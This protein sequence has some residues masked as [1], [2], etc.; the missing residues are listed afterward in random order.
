[1]VLDELSLDNRAQ[2]YDLYYKM[3]DIINQACM[4][5]STWG[6]ALTSINQITPLPERKLSIN[7]ICVTCTHWHADHI[8]EYVDTDSNPMGDCQCP[9]FHYAHE[10]PEYH[11]YDVDS[12]IYF[13]RD[14]RE[15]NVYTAGGFSCLHWSQR[16]EANDLVPD[17]PEISNVGRP[18]PIGV[19]GTNGMKLGQVKSL[20]KPVFS[21]DVESD[22]LHGPIFAIGAVVMT[23]DGTVT[24][25]FAGYA[26]LPKYKSDWVKENVVQNLPKDSRMRVYPSLLKLRSAF[27]KF[28]MW[29][30]EGVNCLS[31]FGAP[32][33]AKLFSECI[34]DNLSERE[35]QGPYPMHELGTM[36][37]TAG[38]DPDVSREEYSGILDKEQVYGT[39]VKHNPVYDSV[40][41]A[42]A[43]FKCV[44]AHTLG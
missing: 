23:S 33:E 44:Q 3:T 43:W 20:G 28:W 4:G 35:W 27:W 24:A 2:V 18:Q 22:G 38:V 14:G 8:R 13:D 36:L 9:K 29:Y 11:K 42:L 34:A 6:E 25:T 12:L 21:V 37:A 17:M 7:K 1:M 39:F 5:K 19:K 16:T 41:A 10:N 15:S 40:A 26:P 32:L 31:D 30:K